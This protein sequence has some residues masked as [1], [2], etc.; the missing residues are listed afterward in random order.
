MIY[1]GVRYN[2]KDIPIKIFVESD[3][4]WCLDRRKK[5]LYWLLFF[6]W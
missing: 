6:V 3:F 5:N 4:T 1:V 2:V